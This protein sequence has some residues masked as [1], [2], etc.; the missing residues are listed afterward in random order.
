MRLSE[1]Y[2]CRTCGAV[3]LVEELIEPAKTLHEAPKVR[4]CPC[5]ACDWE[6]VK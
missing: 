5:G 4:A 2:R 3:R 6:R 1:K